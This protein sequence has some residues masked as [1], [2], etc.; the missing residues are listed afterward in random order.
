MTKQKKT[1]AYLAYNIVEGS[2]ETKSHWTKVGAAWSH[3][4]GDGFTITLDCIPLNG[5]IV[6]R[7]PKPKTEKPAVEGF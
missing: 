3:D 5:R 7:K 1:P 2:D 6:L 4:K